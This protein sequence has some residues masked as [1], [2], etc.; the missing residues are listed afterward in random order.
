MAKRLGANSR[1]RKTEHGRGLSKAA[2]GVIVAVAFS[3]LAAGAAAVVLNQGKDRIIAGAYKILHLKEIVITDISV[4]GGSH[5]TKESVMRQCGLHL[6][7]PYRDLTCC[8]LKLLPAQN[9]WVGCLK[10]GRT[11]GTALVTVTERGFPKPS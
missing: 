1:K 4:T 6:P 5:V 8:C 2:R 3:L 9:P 7:M 10:V 11:H